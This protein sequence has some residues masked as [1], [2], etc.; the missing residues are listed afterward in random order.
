SGLVTFKVDE[1]QIFQRILQAIQQD[2][3]KELDL[4]REVL[5]MLDK[6][7][8]SNAGEFQRYKMYPMIKKQLA[9]DKKVIL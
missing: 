2:Y 5:A 8:K 6:L 7:E 4:D 3:Q 1:K 9:K